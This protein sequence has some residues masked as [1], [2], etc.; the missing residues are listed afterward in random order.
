M[1][2]RYDADHELIL[3]IGICRAPNGGRECESFG[4]DTTGNNGTQGP[5]EVDRDVFDQDETHKMDPK[6]LTPISETCSVPFNEA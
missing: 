6:V 3:S 2:R 5:V 4:S 1:L